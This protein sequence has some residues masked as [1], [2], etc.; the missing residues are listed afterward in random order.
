MA[1]RE[2][3]SAVSM[4]SGIA[5]HVSHVHS[6]AEDRDDPRGEELKRETLRK[7]RTKSS[8]RRRETLQEA[9]AVWIARHSDVWKSASWCS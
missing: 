4:D 6:N 1:A 3:G 7:K 2:S 8:S 9:Q 5:F